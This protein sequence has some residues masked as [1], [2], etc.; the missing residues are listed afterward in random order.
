[1]AALIELDGS[2]SREAAR[3]ILGR[4]TVPFTIQ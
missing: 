1:M 4:F 2:A 3:E